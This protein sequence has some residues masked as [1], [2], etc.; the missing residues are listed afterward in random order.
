[1]NQGHSLERLGRQ[2]HAA[3]DYAAAAEAYERAFASYRREG[4]ILGAARAARTVG[5]FRGWVFGDWAV[6]R[7]WIARARRLLEESDDDRSRAWVSFD[8]ALNGDDL[9]LQRSQYLE[10]IDAARRVGDHDLECDATASLG[11][12]L[13]FSGRADDGMALLDEALASICGGEVAELPVLEGCLCG[14]LTACE[15]THDLGRADEWL[16]A[17]HAV[18]KR[19]NL[20]SVAGYCRSHYA[21]ILVAAGRWEDAEDEL[22]SVLDQLPEGVEVWASARCSLA[23]LRV[24]QGRLE[25]AERLVDG[26]VDHH[27]AIL[28]TVAILLARSRPQPAIEILDRAL[29]EDLA[30]HIAA[31]LLSALIEA[32]LADGD[33]DAAAETCER[34]D[35]AAR[36]G[37]SP[38]VAALAASARARVCVT[39][40]KDAEARARWHEALS[41]F[42][43]ARRNVD[44]ARTRLELARLIAYERPDAAIAELRTAHATFETAGARHSAD[45]AAAL[46]R[47]LGGEATTGPKRHETLTRRENEV[48]GLLSHGLKNAEIAERLFISPKTVEHHVG[49]LLSKLGLRSRVEAA[50]FALRRDASAGVLRP[51]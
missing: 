42:T 35:V 45:E 24:Q 13:V 22:V 38:Y 10:V 5:W 1:M 20:V 8:D 14:M 44:A 33:A 12:M 23:A 17:S 50:T 37:S 6:H 15:Q 36:S 28:P 18:I 29:A 9:D 46:L 48:L 34:L 2:S 51:R 43:K 11:M 21:G 41:L 31:P 30:D 39:L 3:G 32:H 4:D 27:D 49:R 19:H 47:T 40:G 16:R 26:L 7:G 25:D